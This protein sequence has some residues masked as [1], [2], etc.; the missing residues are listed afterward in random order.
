MRLAAMAVATVVCAVAAGCMPDGPVA[1]DTLPP[2]PPGKP[3][4][5]AQVVPD[6][7]VINTVLGYD[8]AEAA[9]TGIVLTSSGR[10]LTNNHVISGSTS[11]KVTDAGD[12]QTYTAHVVGYSRDADLAVLQLD[13][14]HD[15]GV[16]PLGGDLPQVGA[17]V[18]A[19]GNA[20]GGGVLTI[21]AGTVT[22]LGQTVVASD[23]STGASEQL[24]GLIQVD[25]NVQAGDS[26]GPLLDA[27]NRVIGIDTAATTGFRFLSAAH[28][29]FAIPI[30]TAMPIIDEITSG[31]AT[32][33]VHLG[34]T[35]VLGV[36]VTGPATGGGG[37]TVV[38]VVEGSP[39]D[40]A[41]LAEGDVITALDGDRVDS[42]RRLTALMDRRHPGQSVQVDWA[43]ASGA[44]H[45]AH[46]VLTDGPAG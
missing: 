8:D 30:G 7:V 25:A 28:A 36:R 29:G 37:A 20:A 3:A 46:V 39:A 5:P 34:P 6:L 45:S 22:A 38:G 19:V 1:E 4:D 12:K 15:L 9:G 16:A 24:T 18:A 26:G 33:M 35:A 13:G 31:Q 32:D 40:G 23:E 14:A 27:S 10:V 11:I 21:A 44:P 42:P 41:G 2:P 17:P 43:D